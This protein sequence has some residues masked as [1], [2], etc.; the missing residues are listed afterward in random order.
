MLKEGNNQESRKYGTELPP[1]SKELGSKEQEAKA[2]D[3][4]AKSYFKQGNDQE[5][6]KYPLES[7]PISKEL[8]NKEQGAKAH[9]LAKSS[10]N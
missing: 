9:D 8:G 10:R 4:L 7:L 1:I 5:I 6:R 3:V 2:C